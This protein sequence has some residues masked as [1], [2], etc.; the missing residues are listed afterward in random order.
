MQRYR[1]PFKSLYS[2]WF[3][4]VIFSLL[5]FPVFLYAWI[6]YIFKKNKKTTLNQINEIKSLE[7][8]LKKKY[9]FLNQPKSNSALQ[10]EAIRIYNQRNKFNNE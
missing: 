4:R 5:S 3:Y 10:K 9:D 6:T 1:K 2:K 7:A 8:A